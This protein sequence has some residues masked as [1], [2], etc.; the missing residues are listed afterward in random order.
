MAKSKDD[1]FDVSGWGKDAVSLA[2]E[3]LRRF[4]KM[5]RDSVDQTAVFPMDGSVKADEAEKLGVNPETLRQARVFAKRCSRKD[6]ERRIAQARRKLWPPS[7][8]ALVAVY[9]VRDP[10]QREQLWRETLEGRYSSKQILAA[11]RARGFKRDIRH[12]AGRKPRVPGDRRAA[13]Q[14]LLEMGRHWLSAIDAT[15]AKDLLSPKVERALKQTK[16][17]LHKTLA[18]LVQKDPSRAAAEKG[19]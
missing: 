14:R 2:E 1:P 18:A 12:V 15:L 3:Q 6:L 5:G 16:G 4:W 13:Q 10:Q 8:T 17:V 11:Q 9:Q 7:P 19:G